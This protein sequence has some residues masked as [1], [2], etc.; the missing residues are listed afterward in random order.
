[1]CEKPLSYPVLETLGP[2]IVDIYNSGQFERDGPLQAVLTYCITQLN[3]GC[4][5][6]VCV[7]LMEFLENPAET[8]C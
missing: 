5:C 1:M 7:E 3:S 4:P 2:A 6:K 8:Q